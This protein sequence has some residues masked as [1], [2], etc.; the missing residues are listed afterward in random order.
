MLSERGTKLLIAGSALALIVAVAKQR[1]QANRKAN[2]AQ[3]GIAKQ[4]EKLKSQ[5]QKQ[6]AQINR[7]DTQV[8]DQADEIS[9]LKS[10]QQA[11]TNQVAKLQ[12]KLHT[13]RNK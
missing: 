5:D 1:R 3:Q 12:A 8:K 2:Q 6:T 9:K 4:G 13:K 11:L 7:L 10:E